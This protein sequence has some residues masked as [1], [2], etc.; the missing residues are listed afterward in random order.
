MVVIGEEG[1]NDGIVAVFVEALDPLNGAG[2]E[3][4]LEG[5]NFVVA[6]DHKHPVVGGAGDGSD[7]AEEVSERLDGLEQLGGEDDQSVVLVGD[8]VLAGEEGESLEDGVA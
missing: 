2:H 4:W 3:A 7:V 6:E 1:I 5:E 8:E